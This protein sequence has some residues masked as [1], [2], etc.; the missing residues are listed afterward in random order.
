L[1]WFSALRLLLVLCTTTFALAQSTD[2]TISG[3]VVDPSGKGIPGADI[4]ILSEATGVHYSNKTNEI[5]IYTV[6]ILP[7][8]QYRIQV[9]KVGFKTLIK[10]GI[11]LN[12]QSALALNFTLPLGATSESITVEAGAST[13][14]TTDGSVSTVIDRN[15]VANMPLNGRSFQDLLTLAPGVSQVPVIAQYGA[16]SAGEI[17]V[18]GQRTEANYF[19][20]DGVSANTGAAPGKFGGGAGNAG[21]VPGETA[22]GSTQS[23]VPIDALQE[24]R[25]TTSTYSAEYGRTPGGQFSFT[26]RSG[27]DKFHGSLYNY[28]RND[29]LDSNNWFNDYYRYPKGEERQN[30]FGGALGGPVAVPG[31]LGGDRK[32]FFFFAY[33]GLR[34]DA[35]QAATPIS[36]PDTTL[37]SQSAPSIQPILNAFPISNDGDDGL[38]DGLA[39]YIES[40]SYPSS[41]D[42]AG[43]RIDHSFRDSYKIFG[44]Y[45][46]TGS[47]TTAYNAAIRQDTSS[48][49]HT[50]TLGATNIIGA[51]QSNDLRFN[52]T[53]STGRISDVST[54]LG[55]AVSFDPSAIPGPNGG[56]FPATGV[57]AVI[58]DFGAY[59]QFDLE[60]LPTVQRQWN[61]TDVYNWA[62]KSHNLKF[63]VDWRRIS[64]A[65]TPQNPEEEL[66][67]YSSASVMANLADYGYATAQ[68]PSTVEPV[69]IAFSS[70]IQDDWKLSQ[71]LSLALGLRWDINPAPG[72]A[73]GQKPYTLNEVTNLATA[74]LSPSGAPLWKTDWFGLA[75]RLGFAYKVHEQ[76]DR[77]TI[78]RGGVGIFYDMGNAT[79]SIGYNG[80]GIQ[81]NS[82]FTSVAFPLTPQQLQIPPPSIA[83]PYN[84]TV[85]GYDPNLKLPYSLGYNIAIEQQLG[86]NET[87]TFNYVGSG[88]RKLLTEFYTYP[89]LQ[90]NTNFSLYGAAVIVQNRA[91]SS[92]NS[93][94]VKY[95]RLLFRGLQGLISYTWSHAID[96]AS[97]NFLLYQLERGSSDNDIRQNVQAAITCDI[98]D[99][100]IQSVISSLVNHWHVDLRAQTR[101]GLPIDIIGR[102]QI[103]TG[104]G[105]FSSFHP[106]FV[107]GEPVYLYGPHYPGSRIINYAAFLPAASGVEGDVPRNS[108]RGFDAAQLDPAIR[109]DFP[110]HERLGLEFRAEAFN[111]LNHPQFGSFYNSLSYGPTQFGYASNTLNTALGG[112]N[113]LYQVGGPRSL[114][115]ALRLSF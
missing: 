12:V 94:Q 75:P 112:L 88:S 110:I 22:L 17:T 72:A 57:L 43:I 56:A 68:A 85:Y 91:A 98:P 71:R 13:I 26:T 100:R 38:N 106:N 96:D 63:G 89:G 34:L 90:G 74:Q 62:V 5:G 29:A 37:R 92:Y 28:F 58:L 53:Q 59:P 42:N 65:L 1:K 49:I 47:E 93:L 46:A 40:V 115:L 54:S 32:T 6:S 10:P 66:A 70:Y 36:V 111:I 4:E 45:A 113:P 60:S 78:L 18:N 73:A 48:S 19:T 16:G 35:P 41:L 39:Y 83:T 101:S 33:E 44:R 7:P 86:R 15:F 25:A 95:Q 61:I 24:F 51:T 20:V 8:G 27:T 81:S 87:V 31:L 104:T 82:D 9:S 84:G 80:V 114:Q 64:T 55:G 69:Y 11:I 50:V 2:A 30:D 105:I 107:A 21:S 14:N 108:A 97:N 109:R 76:V 77:G 99:A 102:E 103:D 79:G 3:E 52:F 67:Y 23:I